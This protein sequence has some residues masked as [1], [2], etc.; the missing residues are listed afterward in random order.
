MPIR[1]VIVEDEPLSRQYICALLRN[2]PGVEIL[3]TAATEQEAISK[4][5]SLN[6]DLVLLDLELHSGTGLEVARNIKSSDTNIIFT[7]ALDHHATRI[8]RISG[9]PFLQK[10]IDAQELEM[11]VEHSQRRNKALKE[12]QFSYLLETLGNENIPLHMHIP[13]EKE[14]KQTF[15]DDMLIIQSQEKTSTITKTNNSI[16]STC[17]SLKDFEEMLCEF[18][19]FRV[20]VSTIVNMKHISTEIIPGEFITMNNGATVELSSKKRDAFMQ[21]L[22]SSN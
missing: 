15:I 3:D 20:N 5:N 10:P 11:L 4:I 17:L 7:T 19:F 1:A 6:P 18:N 9:M 8:I 12:K 13:E 16:V 21:K 2:I 22:N 14:S